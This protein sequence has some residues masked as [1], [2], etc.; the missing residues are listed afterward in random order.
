MWFNQE[1][2][3]PVRCEFLGALEL[4]MYQSFFATLILLGG[5]TLFPAWAQSAPASSDRSDS[6]PR[7]QA[8]LLNTIKAN[9]AKPN[10]P[11]TAQTVT[12]LTLKEG[13]VIPV[14]STLLGHVLKVE[15]DSADRH[16]SSIEIKFD[17]IELKKKQKF[18]LNLS[19]VSAMAPAAVGESGNKLVTPSGGGLPND[20]PLDGHSYS[21]TDQGHLDISSGKAGTQGKP[22]SAHTGSVIGLPGVT[23]LIDDG[24]EAASTFVSMKKNLQLDS[25][26]Q[27]M[28]VIVQ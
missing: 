20:H 23:L 27:L 1:C 11:I 10:D 5:V 14:G 15:L 26:L 18:P 2:R 17:S 25:G 19:V 6:Q 22:T 13:T 24:P 28:L 16:G 7:V 9:K 21:A 12:P 8:G 4:T 3:P